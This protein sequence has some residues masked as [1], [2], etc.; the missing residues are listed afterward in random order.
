MPTA[1][2]SGG[3]V[4]T[5]AAN[6][7][8]QAA[9]DAAKPGD[10]I[11][12][13]QGATYTGHFTLPNKGTTSSWIIIRPASS[14][15]LPSE[16]TRMSPATAAN[17]RLPRIITPDD[18]AAI[19]TIDGANHYRLVGLEVTVS[20]QASNN[21]LILLGGGDASEGQTTLASVPRDLV[22]DRMYIHGG[23]VTSLKRCIAL[24]SAASAVID[25]YVSE[26]HAEGYDAQAVGGWNGPGPF[27]IVNNYLEGSGENIMFG[28]GDASIT[29]LVPSDIEIR[30]NHIA[31]QT[32][33]RGGRW[34]IKNLLEFKDAQRVLI[35]GNVFE[36]T[37]ASAQDGSALVLW[38]ANQYGRAT[39]TAMRDVTIRKNIIRNAGAGFILAAMSSYQ[40]I[41]AAR[42]AITD[43]LI[44]GIGAPGFDGT[45][46]GFLLG[47][48]GASMSDITIENNTVLGQTNT[49][50]TFTAQPT[51]RLAV[52]NNVLD[53]GQYG[54][55]GDNTGAGVAALNTFAPGADV[56]GN[57]ITLNPQFVSAFPT[58]N[59]YPASVSAIGFANIANQDYRLSSLS[60]YKAQ[61]GARDP[62]ADIDAV[63]TATQ[64]VVP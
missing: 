8:L 4:I 23:S 18:V 9:I 37:W 56:T 25:S 2:A 17:L 58:G 30:R 57:V 24:N 5:V 12:L 34:L 41:P 28:G 14:V 50:I 61:G 60:P 38:S 53:G 7:D 11:E 16:G 55:A 59:A 3:S 15:Q 6:G 46:R 54:I 40:S 19:R 47:G 42:I 31:K 43:N 22:L 32:S 35:E 44:Y 20:S 21:G 1:P 10:V 39:W 49:A 33:W 29:G 36:N 51:V 45:G 13:A 52:R 26:C 27:K 62:G 64:G 48:G 63:M